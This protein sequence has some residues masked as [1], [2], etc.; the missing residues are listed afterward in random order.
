MATFEFSH[1][2]GCRNRDP[3]NCGGCA[4]TKGGASG[5]N[6][7]AWPL[8]YMENRRVIPAKWIEAFKREM[9]S[10]NRAYGENVQATAAR[11]GAEFDNG[12]TF[13]G[14]TWSNA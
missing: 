9:Q 13:D 14:V 11:M 4:L 2:A 7:A 12:A 8:A 5:P 3:D 10:T 1:Y 6:Y